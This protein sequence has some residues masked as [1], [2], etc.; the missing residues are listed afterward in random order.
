VA[1]CIF[2]PFHFKTSLSACLL[3]LPVVSQ[4]NFKTQV[5]VPKQRTPP[6]DAFIYN[7]ESSDPQSSRNSGI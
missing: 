5:G 4:E 2:L 3:P 1:D 7:E 6:G